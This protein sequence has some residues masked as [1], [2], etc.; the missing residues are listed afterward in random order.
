MEF[1]TQIPT[2]LLA[3]VENVFGEN[4][5]W[6]VLLYVGLIGLAGISGLAGRARLVS[7]V[8][9]SYIAVGLLG[10]TGTYDWIVSTFNIPATVWGIAGAVVGVIAVLFALVNHGLGNILDEDEGTMAT[11][12]VLAFSTLG[13]LMALVFTKLDAD[14]LAGFS[15][16]TRALFASPA[17]LVSWMFAPLIIVAATRD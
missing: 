10:M 2:L 5:S 9:A 6:D 4:P 3:L 7:T 13:L 11:S 14:T 1:I 8:V 16:V 15:N 17:G 12:V